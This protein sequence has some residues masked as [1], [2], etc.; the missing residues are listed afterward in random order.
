MNYRWI[1]KKSDLTVGLKA[2]AGQT[3]THTQ[4]AETVRD[5]TVS[6]WNFAPSIKFRYTFGKKEFAR[7]IY[8]GQ[9]TQPSIQQMEPVRNNS[10]AMNETVGNPGLNPSFTHNMRVMYSRFNSDRFSS[11][12]TGLNASLTKDALVNNSI[13]DETGKPVPTD[14]ECRPVALEYR[15]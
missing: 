8:R 14:G 15:G 10:N 2:I 5:T 12:M 9:T 13:Y 4:Y 6:V 3:H 7:I 11:I 1:T